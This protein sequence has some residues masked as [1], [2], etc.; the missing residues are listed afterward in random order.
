MHESTGGQATVSAVV[1]FA[2][3]AV[4]CGYRSVNRASEGRLPFDSFLK[5]AAPAFMHVE[6]RRGVPDGLPRPSVKPKDVARRLMKHLDVDTPW[7]KLGPEKIGAGYIY[8]V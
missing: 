7:G 5:A 6:T 2:A 3:V 8:P 4:S 1:D